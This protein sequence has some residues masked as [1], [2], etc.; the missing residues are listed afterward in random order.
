[1]QTIRTIIEA[2]RDAL[3]IGACCAYLA[4]SWQPEIV[5]STSYDFD[6]QVFLELGEKRFDMRPDV[7]RDI[8]AGLIETAES[9]EGSA[10]G[11]AHN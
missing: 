3:I 9:A 5:D 4:E 6:G 1:M 8:A 11:A 10:P 7:A 2:I